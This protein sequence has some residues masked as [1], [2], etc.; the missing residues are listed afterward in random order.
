MQVKPGSLLIAHPAHAPSHIK[1]NVVFI[2]ESTHRSTVGLTLNRPNRHTLSDIMRSKG[3]NWQ[4]DDQLYTGGDYNTTAMIVLHSEEWYSTST[5]PVTARWGITSD[6]VMLEKFE[7]FNTP[8]DYRIFVGCTGWEPEELE[9]EL[10]G[11]H[12]RWLLMPNPS[13]DL[14]MAEPEH[15]WDLAIIECGHNT[16]KKFF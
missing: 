6:T 15:Q 12:P 16:V 5:M 11:R 14:I 4:L 2:T 10:K 8:M 13:S 7:Q 1:H 3:I 9:D